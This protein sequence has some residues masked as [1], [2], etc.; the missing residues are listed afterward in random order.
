MTPERAAAIKLVEEAIEAMRASATDERE[1][2]LLTGWSLV[3]AF[4]SYDDADGGATCVSVYMPE[5]APPHI[6][7]GLLRAG[8]LMVEQGFLAHPTTES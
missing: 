8:Q 6:T 1:A 2:E 3:C 4:T 5:T 7:M